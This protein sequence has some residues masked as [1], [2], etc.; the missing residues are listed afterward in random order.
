MSHSSL[1]EHESLKLTLIAL[2]LSRG[3]QLSSVSLAIRQ[4]SIINNNNNSSRV[5]SVS[6]D[7]KHCLCV[8]A[9][10]VSRYP[11]KILQLPPYFPESCPCQQTLLCFYS[12]TA[13][14]HFQVMTRWFTVCASPPILTLDSSTGD[15]GTRNDTWPPTRLNKAVNVLKSHVMPC[16]GRLRDWKLLT[17]III[18]VTVKYDW[19]A[20]WWYL[21]YLSDLR[22]KAH[23]LP[24]RGGPG[25]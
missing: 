20:K 17:R 3:C 2:E 8:P 10:L 16:E 19:D 23:S 25:H 21:Y 15:G 7:L 24:W 9:S 18:H 5:Y 6:R 12:T 11:L 14:P 22:Y 1:N 4:T 13:A